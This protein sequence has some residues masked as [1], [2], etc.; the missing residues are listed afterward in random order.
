M[1]ELGD[2]WREVRDNRWRHRMFN[3]VEC[4]GCGLYANDNAVMISSIS[5]DQDSSRC[6][7]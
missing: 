3:M 2:Y 7:W 1:G 6:C 4:E 5:H